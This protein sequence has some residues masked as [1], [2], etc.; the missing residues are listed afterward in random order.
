MFLAKERR[1][2]LKNFMARKYQGMRYL[3]MAKESSE[4]VPIE[5]IGAVVEGKEDRD[6]ELWVID[7]VTVAEVP[8]FDTYKSCKAQAEPH[9]DSLGK[10]SK[11]D[12]MMMQRYDLCQQYI[13][14]KLILVNQEDGQPFAYGDI[15]CQVAR[16]DEV[17]EGIRRHCKFAA[18]LSNH[19]WNRPSEP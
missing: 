17:S 12:C 18:W 15:V 16:T 8:Y 10:C 7:D 5:G 2:K 19:A 3:T 14:A 9:T 13:T 4:I 6:D 1:R 11:I